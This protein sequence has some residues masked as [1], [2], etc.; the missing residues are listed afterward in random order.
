MDQG[1][2]TNK[3]YEFNT[4]KNKSIVVNIKKLFIKTTIFVYKDRNII[5]LVLSEYKIS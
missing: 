2:V 4:N 3:W 1:Y 5:N